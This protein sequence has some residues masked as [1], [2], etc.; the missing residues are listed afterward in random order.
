MDKRREIQSQAEGLRST[1]CV[2]LSTKQT[3]LDPA[4]ISHATRIL[5]A[6]KEFAPANALLA[7]L[8]FEFNKAS[9]PTLLTVANAVL[10]ALKQ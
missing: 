10:E 2:C 8:G 9:W 3:Q 6:A 1:A 7:E 4:V 5:Q